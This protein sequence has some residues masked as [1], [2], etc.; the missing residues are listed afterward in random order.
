MPEKQPIPQPV[1]ASLLPPSEIPPH[2]QPPPPGPMR[3]VQVIPDQAP[4]LAAVFKKTYTIR[5][6]TPCTP[7]DEQIPLDDDGALHDELAPDTPPSCKALPE[8]IGFKSGTDVVIQASARAARPVTTFTVSAQIGRHR[9][10]AVVTGRR[11]CD[12]VNGQLTF[13]SPEPFEEMPLRYE[14]AY[15]GHDPKFEQALM[16]EVKRTTPPENLRRATPAAAVMMKGSNALTYPRNRFGKGYVLE[17]RREFIEGRE[18]PN[19]EWPDDRLIPARLVVG[20]FMD[21]PKQPL[22]VGFDYLDPLAFPRSAMLG[23]QPGF[24]QSADALTEISRGL[25]PADICRGHIM[26][27]RPEDYGKL[28]HPDAGRV[29][30]LGLRMPFLKGNEEILLSGM[31]PAVPEF[32]VVLP[33]ERPE[34]TITDAPGGSATVPGSLLLVFIDFHQKILNLIWGA[35]LPLEHGL[36][37]GQD[38]EIQETT[39]VQM[40][41][42]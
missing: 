13:T 42:L 5:H 37:R 17:D 28:V 35:R 22:P 27:S 2:F 39:S 29:A 6:A 16:E 40:R 21:W 30:S 23:F 9:H 38:K 31:D 14:N 11:F 25:V 4:E 15:G 26:T 7:A 32:R 36:R 1:P 8:I 41:N 18:L 34:F 20:H 19:L 24:R 12:Y 33:G 10:A 3:V